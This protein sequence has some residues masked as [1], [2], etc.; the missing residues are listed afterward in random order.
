RTA[1]GKFGTPPFPAWCKEH[2][3][4]E[5]G[6][7]AHAAAHG[8]IVVNATDGS[9]SI[10]ALELAGEKNLEGKVLI[11]ISNPLAYSRGMPPSLTICNLDSLGE[12][13]QSRFP[14]ARVVKTLNTVNAWVMV[15]PNK[16]NH[17]DHTM[18][19]CGN[20]ASAKKRVN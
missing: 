9:A 4:V 17:G 19:V 16:V 8:E 1:P 5:L 20:D 14:Q 11:D 13:I 2:P 7:F 12:Q 18:F 10:A 3:A 15:G 6:T